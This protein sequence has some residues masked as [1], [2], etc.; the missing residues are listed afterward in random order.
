MQHFS[1]IVPRVCTSVL[2]FIVK[3]LVAS[4]HTH[5]C[6]LLLL[7]LLLLLLPLLPPPPLLTPSHFTTLSLLT[8]L[9]LRPPL[10]PLLSPYRYVQEDVLQPTDV[11]YRHFHKIFEAFRL[12]EKEAPPTATPTAR[13]IEQTPM[14]IAAKSA[15]AQKKQRE[16]EE[17]EE[18]EEEVREGRREGRGGGG[19]GG[20][21]RRKKGGRRRGCC[22]D[23]R[24]EGEGEP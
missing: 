14:T 13:P 1:Q 5:M 11:H 17:E 8:F 9:L 18:V 23:V 16:E 4:I 6:H 21:E 24:G 22:G 15:A 12:T 20:S 7:P 10:L 19:G 2:F 3:V